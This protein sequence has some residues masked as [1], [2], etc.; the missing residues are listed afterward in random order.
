M[1]IKVYPADTM[2]CGHYRMIYPAQALAAAGHDVEL[3]LDGTI[4]NTATVQ[5][6]ND[7]EY[8]RWE[9][10]D[11]ADVPEADVVILQRPS[12]PAVEATIRFLKKRGIQVVVDI[13]DRFDA[14]PSDNMAWSHYRGAN[15][16]HLIRS[17]SEATVVTCSTVDL[18]ELHG[19]IL[20]EN[21]IPEYMLKIPRTDNKVLG[22]S[23]TL[24]VH[25]SD[26]KTVGPAVRQVIDDNVDWEFKVVGEPD[27]VGRQLG[28]PKEVNGTGW[29]D[30]VNYP[31]AVAELGIG[32]APL[33]DNRFNRSKSWLKSLE[34]SALGVPHV[35]SDLPEYRRLGAGMLVSKPRQWK[36][37]LSS[38]MRDPARREEISQQIRSIAQNWTYEGNVNKWAEI[39]ENP[40]GAKKSMTAST[41][42]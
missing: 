42:S 18:A 9:I 25:G 20:L 4:M 19:G 32:I 16:K 40:T 38:L 28:F 10:K 11:A 6:P 30:M 22:W 26:L 29:L 27:G 36:A 5:Q 23:G 15:L 34:Y 2:G 24:R 39:W 13:D 12:H 35:V 31:V 7:D 17:I 1:K 33:Q 14:I 37:A 8:G 3:C 41:F 21:C